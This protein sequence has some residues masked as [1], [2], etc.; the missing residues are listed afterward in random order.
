MF[1][2]RSGLLI[3]TTYTNALGIDLDDVNTYSEIKDMFIL[4]DENKEELGLE[5]VLSFSIAPSQEEIS[6]QLIFY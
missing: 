5:G 2:N 1:V 4:I 3:N 6:I